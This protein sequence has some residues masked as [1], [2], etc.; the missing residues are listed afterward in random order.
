MIRA[1]ECLRQTLCRSS[2]RLLGLTSVRNIAKSL[3]IIKY[4]T[5]LRLTPWFFHELVNEIFYL[6]R[7]LNLDVLDFFIHGLDFRYIF[8]LA[9]YFKNCRFCFYVLEWNIM[10]RDYLLCW[11]DLNFRNSDSKFSLDFQLN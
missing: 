7:Y 9:L 1:N 3:A 6:Y 5:A 11:D 2:Q 4:I 8:K 10:S